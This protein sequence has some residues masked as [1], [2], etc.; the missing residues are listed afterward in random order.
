MTAKRTIRGERFDVEKLVSDAIVAARPNP[1][2]ATAALQRMGHANPDA[3]LVDRY[4]RDAAVLAELQK[5]T[6]AAF[7]RQ[8]GKISFD[9]QVKA[10]EQVNSYLNRRNQANHSRWGK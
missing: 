8:V 6:G 5:A 1:A 2:A 9:D 4:A 10:V 3:A 7:E